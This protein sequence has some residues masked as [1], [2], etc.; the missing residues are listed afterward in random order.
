MKE[1][2]NVYIDEI[3]ALSCNEKT[4]KKSRIRL[5]TRKLKNGVQ[6]IFTG[7]GVRSLDFPH[8]LIQSNRLQSVVIV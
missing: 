6:P 3:L 4:F 2:T 7:F 5:L 1:S 8:H